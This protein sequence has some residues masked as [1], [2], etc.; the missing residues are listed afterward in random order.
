MNKLEFN[1]LATA[2]GVEGFESDDGTVTLSAEMA[3]AVETVL[4]QAEGDRTALQAQ[5]ENATNQQQIIATLEAELQTAINRIAELSAG[6]G[7]ETAAVHSETDDPSATTDE[8][9]WG[10]LSRLRTLKSK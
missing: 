6:P 7:A 10:R 8:G 9:F 5:T 3:H 4:E 1:R 2:A